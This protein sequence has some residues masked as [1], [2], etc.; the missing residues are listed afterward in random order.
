MIDSNGNRLQNLNQQL[1]KATAF[2]ESVR[3]GIRVRKYATDGIVNVTTQTGLFL[4]QASVELIAELIADSG[5]V[6]YGN[7]S[8]RVFPGSV[9]FSYKIFNWPFSSKSDRLYLELCILASGTGG[10]FSEGARLKVGDGFIETPFLAFADGNEVPINVFFEKNSGNQSMM[11][12]EFPSFSKDLFYDPIVSLSSNSFSSGPGEGSFWF[13]GMNLVYISCGA[14]A[15]VLGFA[16]F[17]ILLYRRKRNPKI[18]NIHL[19]DIL[20][21]R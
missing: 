15:F 12:F 14:T 11:L 18:G 21:K 9:K 10:V 7:L 6:R 5:T 13:S 16:V 8:I 17:A 19:N 2:E 1:W 20:L 3:D 4:G